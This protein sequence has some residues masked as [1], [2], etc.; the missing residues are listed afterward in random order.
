MLDAEK[1]NAV[2]IVSE[3]KFLPWIKNTFSLPGWS[4]IYIILDA[5]KKQHFVQVNEETLEVSAD[6]YG[7]QKVVE[8][9]ND[10][11]I[12]FHY[13]LNNT[14]AEIISG[15]NPRLV[16]CWCFYGAE[17]Y[18]QTSL[19]RKNLYGSQTR[20]LF[21]YLPEIRFRYDLRRIYYTYVLFRKAPIDSLQEAIP[22]IFRILWYVEEEMQLINQH[23]KLPLWQFFQFFSFADIIPPNTPMTDFSSKKILIGNSATIENNH[24]DILPLIKEIKDGDYRFSL[25]M[26]YGQFP[27]YMSMIKK[28][29][30]LAL[31][32][33]VVFLEGHLPLDEYY[34]FLQQHPTAI[35]LHHRQQG[36]GNILY[37]LYTGTKVYLSRNNIIQPWL[38]NNGVKVFS[39]ED[40]FL[41]DVIANRL[42]LDMPTVEKNR[43]ALTHMLEHHRNIETLQTLE[44]E[45]KSRKQ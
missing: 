37:L 16:H 7:E 38:S 27:R 13:L 29:Y 34:R 35:F 43:D 45:V 21:R 15:S 22:H 12:V 25:P 9:I 1:I 23:I 24:A 18:Q 14:K 11:D 4:S 17:I 40:E 10:Y 6:Q 19:F 36:L 8:K 5:S 20:K 3:K 31:Q 32:D 33:R 2:H 41:Q 26:T 44:R 42:T 30:R 39:F 28:Q